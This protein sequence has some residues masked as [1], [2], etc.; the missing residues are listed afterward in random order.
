[1][2]KTFVFPHARA[3]L[4]GLAVI[5]SLAFSLVPVASAQAAVACPQPNSGGVPAVN[6]QHVFCGEVAN[7]RAKGFHSRPGGQ[8]PATVAFTAATTNTPVGPAGIYVLRSFNITQNGVTASKSISTMF[9]D[10]CSQANVVAAIQNAYNNRTSL[11]GN[12]FRGPSGAHCVAGNPGASFN[13]VGYLNGA[14]TV[15]TTAYPDY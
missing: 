9:P 10:S 12:E 15:V 11:N 13:I 2:K 4:A 1:M 5:G 7:N 6:Q 3:A 8:L 14:G